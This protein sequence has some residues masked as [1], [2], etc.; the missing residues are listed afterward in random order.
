MDEFSCEW[1]LRLLTLDYHLEITTIIMIMFGD[2][3]DSLLVLAISTLLINSKHV[4]EQQLAGGGSNLELGS[5]EVLTE[6]FLLDRRKCKH[7]L[8]AGS[9]GAVFRHES[10]SI[11]P[12][13][14]RIC[15]CSE[16]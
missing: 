7:F 4:Q 11:H 9:Y 12:A 15:K 14:T 16:L 8:N 10:F 1:R 13:C 5:P 2:S 3:Q 6:L